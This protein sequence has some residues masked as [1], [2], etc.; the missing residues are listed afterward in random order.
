VARLGTLEQLPIDYR[1]ALTQ[2]NL[3]PLWPNLRALLPHGRPAHRTQPTL[4][5]YADV[6][7]LLLRAGQLTPIEQAERRVLVLA[8]PGFGAESLQATPS[9]YVGLQLIQPGEPAPNHRHTPS[10][11]RFVVEGRGG[12]TVV[13]GQRLAM[14]RGDL[15]LTPAGLWHEHGHNGEGPV[16]W[17]DALDLP[18][19]YSL[20]ASFAIE[21]PSR[22]T[23]AG[24][25]ASQARYRRSGLLPYEVLDTVRPRY[26]M[27]RYPWSEVRSA[28]TDMARSADPD[29]LIRLAYVN[30]QTGEECLPTLGFSALM[31]RPAETVQLPRCSASAV[32]HVIE[33]ELDLQVDDTSHSCT[34]NDT[35][36]IPTHASVSLANRSATK[37][38]FLFLID[39]A[40][41]QRKLG[42]YEVFS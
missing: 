23:D 21:G 1:Q 35:A 39:D 6:R 4:W 2:L 36:A 38:A 32:A 29:E 3:V 24:L 27:L 33:G 19:V 41:L 25:D 40:P 12:Y 34:D 15:I 31:L 13:D 26:P 30:P 28:L 22:V 8:N 16:I 10:A 20:E 14:E 9:I 37:P 42:F 7:P 18:L 17:L 11:V 5:R